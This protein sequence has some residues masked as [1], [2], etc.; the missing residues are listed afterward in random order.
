MKKNKQFFLIAICM[1]FGRFLFSQNDTFNFNIST[2]FRNGKSI[3]ESLIKRFEM[4]YLIVDPLK[5]DTFKVL[6]VPDSFPLKEYRLVNID[7]VDARKSPYFIDKLIY[8]ITKDTFIQKTDTTRFQAFIEYHYL[9]ANN[10]EIDWEGTGI[11]EDNSEVWVHPPRRNY[12]Y[13]NQWTPFPNIRF[14]II[15]G[16]SWE[17]TNPYKTSYRVSERYETTLSNEKCKC[18]KISASGFNKKETEYL[19]SDYCEKF[20]FVHFRF[21]GLDRKQIIINLRPLN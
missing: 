5:K 12:F 18:W 21:E 11:I 20:G 9:N 7:D 16:S 15:E 19:F 2:R 8:D 3:S 17:S 13:V 14:Q 1:L 6:L 10:F 4:T